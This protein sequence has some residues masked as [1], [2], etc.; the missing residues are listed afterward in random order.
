MET[1]ACAR[2]RTG[3]GVEGRMRSNC[4]EQGPS[5]ICHRRLSQKRK[6]DTQKT[7]DLSPQTPDPPV[8]WV[9]TAVGWESTAV[10]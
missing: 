4:K 8:G 2:P 5:V 10:G 9:S 6:I 1:D 7:S 3:G